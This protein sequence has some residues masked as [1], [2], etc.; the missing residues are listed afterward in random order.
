MIRRNML[1]A[2]TV[3]GSA[4]EDLKIRNNIS[5]REVIMCYYLSQ[6][7][8]CFAGRPRNHLNWFRMRYVNI[9]RGYCVFMLIKCGLM[10]VNGYYTFGKRYK[11]FIMLQLNLRPFT[12]LTTSCSLSIVNLQSPSLH[13]IFISSSNY[14]ESNYTSTDLH[15]TKPHH[16]NRNCKSISLVI[17]IR[18]IFRLFSIMSLPS[19]SSTNP[20][21]SNLLL[22]PCRLLRVG[23]ILARESQY[24][25]V[26]IVF[27]HYFAMSILFYSTL[28]N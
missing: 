27:C 18:F 16:S 21:L 6:S 9:A 22:Y 8:W 3:R 12:L 28:R 7:V 14:S 4:D 24:S 13:F 11:T 19:Y 23:Y 15:C 26:S 5:D 25:P 2:G 17:S 1:L 10:R 20:Y